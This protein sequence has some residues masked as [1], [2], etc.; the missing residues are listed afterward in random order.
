MSS[1]ERVATRQRYAARSMAAVSV[2]VPARDAAATLPR[3]LRGLEAQA[4]APE[5]EVIVVDDGSSDATADLAA[6]SPAV[7]E[8]VRGGGEGPAAARNAGAARARGDALAFLDADCEPAPGWLSAGARALESADLVQGAVRPRPDA[9]PGPFDRTL[10]VS[11]AY[12][13]FESANLFLDR[14]LF[15]RLGGFES[16]LRPR[17]GIELGEDVWLGW[18]ARRAGARTAFAPDALAWHEVFARDARAYA[19]ERA[20][21]RHFPAL[22]ARIPE[23]REEFLFR[24]VFLNRRSALFDLALAGAALAAARRSPL[25]LLVA[26][27]YA[28]ELRGHA[29][30]AG[31]RWPAVAAAD[32][33]ADAVGA[34]ALVAGSVQARSAVL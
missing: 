15:E 8:L 25:A 20:R 32:A 27:P 30:R 13:L 5:H 2:I 19:A 10:A 6:G 34:A 12:G 7:T 26:L 16:W 31:A 22:A 23:L 18:R 9:R 11:H 24:R 21:L 33:A 14:G 3:T 29:L 17:R 28:R 1:R 4:D